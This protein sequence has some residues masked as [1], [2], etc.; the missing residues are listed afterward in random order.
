MRVELLRDA[1]PRV[2]SI[3]HVKERPTVCPLE[4]FIAISILHAE[5]AF[6]VAARVLTD[7]QLRSNHERQ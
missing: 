5:A 3:L 4:R 7:L 1:V 6:H 2:Q